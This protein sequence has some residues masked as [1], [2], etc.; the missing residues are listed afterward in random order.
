M[1]INKQ[2]SFKLY[3]ENILHAQGDDDSSANDIEFQCS[4]LDARSQTVSTASNVHAQGG[5]LA[6]N[7][8]HA[9]G[10]LG[11]GNWASSNRCPTSSAI[12]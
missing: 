2:I 3:F 4:H 7:L 1:A 12:C 11:N 6:G 5:E 10:G 9:P 8:I